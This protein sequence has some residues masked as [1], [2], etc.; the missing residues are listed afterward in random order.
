MRGEV[1]G[2]G[3]SVRIEHSLQTEGMPLE[4]RS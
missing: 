3:V 2:G 4:V 1:E